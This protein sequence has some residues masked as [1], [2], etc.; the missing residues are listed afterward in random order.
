M[1]DQKTIGGQAIHIGDCYIWA[2]IYYLDSSTDYSEYISNPNPERIAATAGEF[3][4]LDNGCQF[5]G[6]VFEFLIV[7]VAM[8]VPLRS[9]SHRVA[10][11]E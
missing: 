11:R 9:I 6:A 8:M 5:W 10:P 3:V 1:T 7:L 4:T 2:E